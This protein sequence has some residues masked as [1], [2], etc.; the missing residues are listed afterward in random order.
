MDRSLRIRRVMSQTQSSTSHVVAA[1]VV[2]FGI[3]LGLCMVISRLIYFQF[4]SD[5]GV[6]SDVVGTSVGGFVFLLIFAA[7]LGLVRKR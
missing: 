5:R 2:K 6:D 1:H 7:V 4:F 3:P